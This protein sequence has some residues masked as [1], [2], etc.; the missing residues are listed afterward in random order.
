[1][2]IE[3]WGET[4]KNIFDENHFPKVFPIKDSISMNV[5]WTKA[6]RHQLQNLKSNLNA[7]Q[8]AD[9]VAHIDDFK[10]LSARNK[11]L[12][13]EN[14]NLRQ[15]LKALTEGKNVDV[16]EAIN[17]DASKKQQFSAQLEAQNKLM[18][19]RPDWTFPDKYG[20]CNE[21]GVPYNFSVV[22]INDETGEPLPIVL[23][24]YKSRQGKFKINPEEWSWVV[25]N[26]AKLLVYT[27]IDD[28]LDIVE[29][30]QNDLVMNQSDISITFSSENLDKEKY[31]ERVSEFAETLHYFTNLHFDFNSFHVEGNAKRVRDIYAK[32]DG[33]QTNTTDN[34]L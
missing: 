26:D 32:R 4:N 5:V 1:M 19:S 28:N 7:E 21:E 16:S 2:L 12:E 18:G 6:E 22:T 31:S 11:E 33:M 15:M 3:E 8:L 25:E 17:G 34:D 30:P 9:L 23:K 13:N 24:S 27:T 29:V 10:D 20:E 14:E